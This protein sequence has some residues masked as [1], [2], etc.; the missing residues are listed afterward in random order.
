MLHHL[1]QH[2][3]APPDACI[4]VHCGVQMTLTM[5]ATNIDKALDK[6]HMDIPCMYLPLAERFKE[7]LSLATAS[8]PINIIL[9]GFDS[10]PSSD[11]TTTVTL[12]T[13]ICTLHR[14]RVDRPERRW[15]CQHGCSEARHG[16]GALLLGMAS[17][18]P[19]LEAC[20]RLP[21]R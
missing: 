6:T 7:T 2:H 16:F 14:H 1:L 17:R 4:N 19:S 15:R 9:D 5:M 11:P 12:R 18:H 8:K 3:V 10:I 21:K 13:L 20:I